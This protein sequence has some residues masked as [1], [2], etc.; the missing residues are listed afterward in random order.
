MRCRFRPHAPAAMTALNHGKHVYCQ[1]PLTHEVYEA[2]RL[3]EVAEKKG[4]FA[5]MVDNASQIK[6]EWLEGK[7]R[8]GVTAGASASEKVASWL[9]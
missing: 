1:K 7:R 6:P 5:N 3:R 2:R 4:A 9:S 8:I